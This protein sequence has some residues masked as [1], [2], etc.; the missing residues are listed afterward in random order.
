MSWMPDWSWEPRFF[1]GY[2]YGSGDSDPESKNDRA[3]RQTGLE[4][5]DAGFGG[6]EEFPNYGILIDPELSNIGIASVGVG[7]ALFRAS[8]LDLVYHHYRLAEPAESL[9]DSNIEVE[10]TGIDRDFGQALD[11]VLALEEWKQIEL[12]LTVSAF[13]AGRAFGRDHGEMSYGGFAGVRITF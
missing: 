6:V 11:L 3:F 1:A 4:S 5:N 12:L 10:L 7:G 9:R 2:A 8:S 13:R